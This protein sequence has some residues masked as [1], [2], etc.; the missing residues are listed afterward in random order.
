MLPSK[1]FNIYSKTNENLQ[2]LI[3]HYFDKYELPQEN[4][5]EYLQSKTKLSL[6]QVE[7]IARKLSESWENIFS[8]FFK[9]KTTITNLM[10]YGI[11]GLTEKESDWNIAKTSSGRPKIKEFIK[12]VKE[13]EID[14]QYL[15]TNN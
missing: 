8:E 2:S 12:F 14:F 3:S 13:T 11:D 9:G 1:E 10:K 4:A 6:N 7:F 5:I 15:K